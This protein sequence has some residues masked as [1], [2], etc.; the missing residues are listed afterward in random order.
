MASS[1]RSQCGAASSLTRGVQG[2]PKVVTSSLTLGDVQPLTLSIA[3]LGEGPGAV[4]GNIPARLGSAETLL[5]ARPIDLT[6]TAGTEAAQRLTADVVRLIQ[7]DTGGKRHTGPKGMPRALA[8]TASILAG[9]LRAGLKGRA[10]QAQ[11]RPAAYLWKGGMVGQRAFWAKADVMIASG[12]LGTKLGIKVPEAGDA[13]GDAPHMFGGK[14]TALWPT[15]KLV[16][17]AAA[18]GLTVETL[19]ADWSVSREA[20][21]RPIELPREKLVTVR[22]RDSEA[23]V[24]VGAAHEGTAE[25]M[26]RGAERLNTV[27]AEADIRGCPSVAFQRLCRVDLRLGARHYAIGVSNYQQMP[28]DERKDIRINGE[29]VVELDL[30]AS[31]LSILLGLTGETLPDGDPYAVAGLPRSVVKAWTTMTL[32][33]GRPAGQWSKR[34]KP[35]VKEWRCVAV[36]NA[37]LAAFPCLADMPAILPDDLLATLSREDV[38][39]AAGQFLVG[40]EAAI[41]ADAINIVLDAGGVALPIHDCLMVPQSCEGVARSALR[42]AFVARVGIAPVVS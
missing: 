34:T 6:R 32:G 9:V 23:L 39:W 4:C 11:R 19:R 10:V 12:L 2:S 31:H 35:V 41:V 24:A 28:S 40:V 20:E 16:A 38:H 26:R 25:A 36:R 21:T 1:L 29:A 30:R 14:P 8:E 18:H 13:F 5:D 37:M 27:V 17:M 22:L 42:A 3:E 7:A 33:M 15:A